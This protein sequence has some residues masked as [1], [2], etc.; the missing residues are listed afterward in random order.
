MRR[1]VLATAACAPLLVAPAAHPSHWPFAGGDASRSGTQGA[2]DGS[3]PVAPAWIKADGAVHTPIV[4]TGGAGPA[5]QRVA[6]GTVDGSVHLRELESGARVGPDPAPNV[7]GG[8]RVDGDPTFGGAGASIGFA[9]TSTEDDLGQLVVVHNDDGQVAVARID[10]ATGAYDPGSEYPVPGSLGCEVASSP[11]LTPP[12]AAG[13]RVLFFTM[14]GACSANTSLVRLPIEGDALERDAP[15]GQVTYAPISGSEPLT[16][17]ASPSLLVLS[18]PAT[19][20]PRFF[21]AVARANG[22]S[23]FPADASLSPGSPAPGAVAPA[24]TAALEAGEV[25]QSVVAPAAAGGL[26][27]G[28]EG[29]GSARAPALYV[30]A[31]VAG[32][33]STAP[34]ATKIYRFVQDDSAAVLRAAPGP[35]RLPDDSGAPAPALAVSEVVGPSGSAAGGR[36]VVATAGNLHVLS[37]ETLATVGRP[38]SGAALGA[39]D[40]FTRTWPALAGGLAYLQRD[41]AADRAATHMVRPVADLQSSVAFS[42]EGLPNGAAYGQ[43]AISRGFVVLGSPA[44]VIAYRSRDTGPPEAALVSPPAGT[45]Q[46]GTITVAAEA[47]D[48]RG[49]VSVAFRVRPLRGRARSI[50]V[51]MEPESGSDWDLSR[52]GRFTIPLQTESLANGDYDLEAVAIDGSGLTTTSKRRLRI[53]NGANRVSRTACA[54][55]RTGTRKADRLNGTTRGD[56]LLGGPGADRLRGGRGDDCLLGQ[57]GNDRLDG[58]PGADLLDGGPGADTLSAGP[59]ADRVQARDKRRDTIRC[60]SGRDRVSADRVDRVARDCERVTRR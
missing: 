51:A 15:W 3:D 33:D 37:T 29:S 39:G 4:I 40:G 52:T 35:A 18:D 21:V 11:V 28:G 36:L 22:V 44:G 43:P 49:V 59:G 60:G 53:D 13:G 54:V 17:T 48:V 5:A 20:R 10:A 8:L 41:G 56:R 30:A 58:G 19:A 32:P 1:L 31:S 50:G 9:D 14:S 24:I 16:A 26:V 23:M 6:Y 45:P 38:L 2:H 42:T 47:A 46:R 34:D 27:A 57:A 25:A 55:T 7:D 12:N